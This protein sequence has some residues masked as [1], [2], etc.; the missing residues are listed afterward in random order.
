MT[1]DPT[2]DP[3]LEPRLTRPWYLQTIDALNQRSES[4]PGPEN[5]RAFETSVDEARLGQM[6]AYEKDLFERATVKWWPSRAEREAL[7]LIRD[8]SPQVRA[9]YEERIIQR[10]I[11]HLR[12]KD[13]QAYWRSVQPAVTPTLRE[14]MARFFKGKVE[15]EHER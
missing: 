11:D 2:N 1:T 8:H 7:S 13:R 10:R 3:L 6:A 14:R 5:N 9:Y 4:S 12:E 15:Q